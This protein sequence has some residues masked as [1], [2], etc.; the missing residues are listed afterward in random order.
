LKQSPNDEDIIHSTNIS[1]RKTLI[2]HYDQP[3]R[4]R[5]RINSSICFE[6][7]EFDCANVVLQ[8]GHMT[9]FSSSFRVGC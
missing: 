2:I 5:P 7:T 3:A 8:T 6:A 1:K 9:S 4:M